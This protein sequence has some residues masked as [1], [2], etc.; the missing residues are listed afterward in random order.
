MEDHQLKSPTV[1]L[2]LLCQKLLS[3]FFHPVKVL[4]LFATMYSGKE[5]LS[6]AFQ[7][8]GQHGPFPLSFCVQVLWMF[9]DTF[10]KLEFWILEIP[11]RVAND[12]NSFLFLLVVLFK[13]LSK[14]K[15]TLLFFCSV[16]QV[17]RL[18]EPSQVQNQP[19][20]HGFPLLHSQAKALG[21][22]WWLCPV[23]LNI[24]GAMISLSCKRTASKSRS[25]YYLSGTKTRHVL[26]SRCGMLLSFTRS[27]E[28]WVPPCDETAFAGYKL[29]LRRLLQIWAFI[30]TLAN[31]ACCK[32][33]V[34]DFRFV[35]FLGC[36]RYLCKVVIFFDPSSQTVVNLLRNK[37]SVTTDSSSRLG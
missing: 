15:I 11:N 13:K 32:P 7:G 6:A 3:L 33:S 8:E 17:S 23:L 5:L 22:K 4:L 12:L 29:Y 16:M 31:K 19:C 34:F 14:G 24:S 1:V 37:Q 35:H 27:I 30:E 21:T 2:W 9:S 10:F 26:L 18:E 36:W 28:W 20:H 25:E